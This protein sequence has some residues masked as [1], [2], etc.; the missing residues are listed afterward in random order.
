MTFVCILE[1]FQNNASLVFADRVLK[2]LGLMHAREAMKTKKAIEPSL[3]FT[4]NYFKSFNFDPIHKVLVSSSKPKGFVLAV[5][6]FK[7]GN[8]GDII[9]ACTAEIEAD[10]SEYIMEAILLRGTFHLLAGQYANALVDFDRVI[11]S[12]ADP[13]LKSNALVKR[14]S[15]QMQTEQ[16]E[17][18]FDDFAKAIEIDPENPDTYHHR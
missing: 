12:N 16:R 15:L 2:D 3:H 17:K 4:T 5:K 11:S 13:K 14:A 9:P 7:D 10:H 8:I 6:S 18:S 1:G